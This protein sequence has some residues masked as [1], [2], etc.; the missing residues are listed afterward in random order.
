[1]A[2]TAAGKV[3]SYL[4][5]DKGAGHLADFSFVTGTA[6]IG[7][8]RQWQERQRKVHRMLL[9]ALVPDLPDEVDQIILPDES[10]DILTHIMTFLYSGRWVVDLTYRLSRGLNICNLFRCEHLQS[11]QK[12]TMQYILSNMR[13]PTSVYRD[14]SSPSSVLHS[15]SHRDSS[16][17]RLLDRDSSPDHLPDRD[18]SSDRLLDDVIFVLDPPSSSSPPGPQSLL[19]PHSSLSNVNCRPGLK[20]LLPNNLRYE[21][22]DDDMDVD[23]EPQ[24]EEVLVTH[25]QLGASGDVGVVQV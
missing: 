23:Q 24:L 20:V 4:C 25:I 8:Q 21:S 2:K 10:P 12:A 7:G 15:R 5:G 19:T 11:D 9:C 6:V 17:P 22:D 14:R 18:S 1:M 13:V 3:L 16:P